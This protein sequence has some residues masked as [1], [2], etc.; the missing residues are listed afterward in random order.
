MSGAR[1]FASNLLPPRV[2]E[3]ER[4]HWHWR[5]VTHQYAADLAV[6]LAG[7]YGYL[8]C[9]SGPIALDIVIA[10]RSDWDGRLKALCDALQALGIVS[11]DSQI[12]EGRV[13][14]AAKGTMDYAVL[15]R[16][17]PTQETDTALIESWWGAPVK[18]PK[19]RKA[20]GMA[21]A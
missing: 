19:P 6:E 13:L 1:Q 21:K 16:W 2:N 3:M 10:N 17:R 20:N 18:A 5:K 9:M 8:E 14:K 11:D 4:G 7:E 12:V 15:V